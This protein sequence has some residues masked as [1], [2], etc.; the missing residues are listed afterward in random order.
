MKSTLPSEGFIKLPEVLRH[1][2]VGKT[3]WYEGIKA[4]EFPK[5]YPVPGC[6]RGVC[7]DVADVRQVIDRIRTQR[8]LFLSTCPGDRNTTASFHDGP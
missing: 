7:W 2:P 5:S 8:D 3:K 6:S 1:V 4:G